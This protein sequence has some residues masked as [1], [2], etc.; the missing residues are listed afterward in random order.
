MNRKLKKLLKNTYAKDK[1]ERKFF[2]IQQIVNGYEWKKIHPFTSFF[3]S[4]PEFLPISAS[5]AALAICTVI[6][7]VGF[8][9]DQTP[10]PDV[11]PNI[12]TEIPV[13][14]SA[15]SAISSE[16][17]TITAAVQ[18]QTEHLADSPSTT[19][20]PI[21]DAF[22]GIFSIENSGNNDT[23]NSNSTTAAKADP[24]TTKAPTTASPTVTTSIYHCDLFSHDYHIEDIINDRSHLFAYCDNDIYKEIFYYLV[25]ERNIDLDDDV[26]WDECNFIEFFYDLIFNPFFDNY[27]LVEGEITGLEYFYHEGKPWTICEITVSDVYQ[28]LPQN[29]DDSFVINK[30]DKIR[31]AEA[32]G[33]MP[34]KDYI[35]L[36]PDD[37]R[38]SGWSEN[39]IETTVIYSDGSN[40]V[41]PKI[42]DSYLF[43]F[44]KEDIGLPVD[45]YFT[46][47]CYT[48]DMQ[49]IKNNDEFHNS[50]NTLSVPSEK[51]ENLK[52]QSVSF[53]DPDT[54]R[55]VVFFNRSYL[56]SG[57]F[58]CYS[59]DSEGKLSYVDT[60][61]TDDGYF[62]FHGT[63]EES[64][65]EQGRPI[66]RGETY[67]MTW[68]DTGL[69]LDCFD[70][71]FTNTVTIDLD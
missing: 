64:R 26:N 10:Q 19:K 70:Y 55:T 12:V 48:D 8:G 4:H 3:H 21:A 5:V 6:M 44:K 23:D 25:N 17:T 39:R 20:N 67:V 42:G 62:P 52:D 34:V 11:P 69:I 43:S 41:E 56:L 9:G 22:S 13:T 54:G 29:I 1:P 31:I 14:S 27:N 24:K 15:V 28:F 45:N 16:N 46:R 47:I 71:D 7:F 50:S 40:R 68:T 63:Y 60:I 59:V 38:F 65:D 58:A 2:F 66:V 49:L 35:S 18:T 51:V 61:M 37:T 33:Y 36:N 30:G 53:T 32:G 57:E